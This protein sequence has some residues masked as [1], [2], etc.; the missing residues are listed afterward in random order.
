MKLKNQLPVTC[1][2]YEDNVDGDSGEK[3]FP[4][5]QRHPVLIFLLLQ[6]KHNIYITLRYVICRGY[7]LEKFQSV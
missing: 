7:V 2:E 6:T 4:F 5:S 1:D 3:N